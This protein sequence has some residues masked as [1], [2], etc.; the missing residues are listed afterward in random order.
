M[1]VLTSLF[2]IKSTYD[3]IKEL[4]ETRPS[5]EKLINVLGVNGKESFKNAVKYFNSYV[6]PKIKPIV[7]YQRMHHDTQRMGNVIPN[8]KTRVCLY[9]ALH[10]LKLR[11]LLIKNF[12]DEFKSNKFQLKS[13]NIGETEIESELDEKETFLSAFSEF[14]FNKNEL[15][16]KSMIPKNKASKRVKKLLNNEDSITSEQLLIMATFQADPEKPNVI[17]FLMRDIKASIFVCKLIFAKMDLL[18]PFSHL[19]EILDIEE[20]MISNDF[21]PELIP[22]I[23]KNLQIGNEIQVKE[24][25]K[26]F[27]FLMDAVLN[28]INKVIEISSGGQIQIGI[29]DTIYNSGDLLNSNSIEIM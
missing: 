12:V 6:I 2:L 27:D 14:Y 26:A 16:L 22:A 3:E 19:E 20:L 9:F 7:M 17:K 23:S 4:P 18:N 13:K 8:A 24:C 5:S 28:S 1:E 29:Y 11:F 21:I 25:V 10:R 15:M